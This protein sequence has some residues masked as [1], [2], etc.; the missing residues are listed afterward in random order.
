MTRSRR[1]LHC[2]RAEYERG[3]LHSHQ[4]SHSIV[5]CAYIASPVPVYTATGPYHL[6]RIIVSTNDV[7][8]HTHTVAVVQRKSRFDIQ[9]QQYIPIIRVLYTIGYRLRTKATVHVCH[10]RILYY[11]Y[12]IMATTARR[13]LYT[14]LLFERVPEMDFDE[15][16]YLKRC[17][18]SSFSV[19]I[20]RLPALASFFSIFLSIII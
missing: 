2:T 15:F 6:V 7:Y 20:P 11:T 9:S 17:R 4:R 1:L 19:P 10:T 12:S 16:E 18:L 14:Y 3:T 5:L 13:S 8:I